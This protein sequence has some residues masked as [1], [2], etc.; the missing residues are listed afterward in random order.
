MKRTFIFIL[1]LTTSLSPIRGQK[2]NLEP[3]RYAGVDL[4]VD[5]YF[6]LTF[7]YDKYFKPRK[8]L[9]FSFGY[10]HHKV[11]DSIHTLFVTNEYTFRKVRGSILSGSLPVPTSGSSFIGEGVP[12][13]KMDK[14][15]PIHAMPFGVCY[16]YDL[17]K[18]PSKVIPFAGVGL[19]GA[20][21]WGYFVKDTKK[22]IWE[23][24]RIGRKNSIFFP[25]KTTTTTTH[26]SETRSVSKRGWMSIGSY[27][28]FGFDWRLDDKW[29]CALSINFGANLNGFNSSPSPYYLL[30]E[31]YS[32]AHF[33]LRYRI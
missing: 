19:W 5:R 18:K 2:T 9:A 6:E 11:P 1:I 23:T 25:V 32:T 22:K 10:S 29:K 24:V 28:T 31:F 3:T 15:M 17:V 33:S 16:K 7:A 14:H 4:M 26:Y 12:L 13:P 20:F 8:S 30:N 27:V 21:Y